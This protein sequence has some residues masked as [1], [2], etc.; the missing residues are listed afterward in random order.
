[1][2]SDEQ[3]VAHGALR[4]TPGHP[5]QRA[6]LRRAAPLAVDMSAYR[7]RWREEAERVAER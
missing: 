1:L 6:G 4:L 2:S 5:V 7:A 3:G